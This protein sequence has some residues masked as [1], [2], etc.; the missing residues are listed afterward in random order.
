LALAYQY[1]EE[2]CR[3]CGGPMMSSPYQGYGYC[4]RCGTY[5]SAHSPW[6]GQSWGGIWVSER[7]MSCGQPIM[8]TA[9]PRVNYCPYCGKYQYDRTGY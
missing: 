3:K 8:D 6:A 1:I 5:E 2:N 4:P 9:D 7:C